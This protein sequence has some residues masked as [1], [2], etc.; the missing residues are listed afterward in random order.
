MFQHLKTEKITSKFFGD[1]YWLL[2][3]MSEIVFDFFLEVT[4][5]FFTFRICN[6]KIRNCMI[7]RWT[8]SFSIIRGSYLGKLVDEEILSNLKYLMAGQ[9]DGNPKLEWSV[10][11]SKVQNKK[12]R[13]VFL[14]HYRP[15]ILCT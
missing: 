8:V 5:F 3:E 6:F 4:Q 13:P 2:D 1:S 11:H 15:D 12:V 10:P 9:L 14:I 7:L